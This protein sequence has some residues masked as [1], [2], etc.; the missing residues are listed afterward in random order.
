MSVDHGAPVPAY[1]QLAEILKARIAQGEWSHGP[2]PSVRMLQ[3]EYEVGRDT[4]AR[5]LDE[6]RA[7]GVIFTVERRGSYVTRGQAP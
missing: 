3:Q 1:R 5:A 2:L 7:E 6:L 4:A